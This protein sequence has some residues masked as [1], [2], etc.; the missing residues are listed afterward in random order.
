MLIFQE[1]RTNYS[2]DKSIKTATT[3]IMTNRGCKSNSLPNKEPST[4]SQDRRWQADLLTCDKKFAKFSID[5]REGADGSHRCSS[6]RDCATSESFCTHVIDVVSPFWWLSP[7]L[8]SKALY[9]P[10]QRLS[11]IV[12]NWLFIGP[13]IL[14]NCP[15]QVLHN[16]CQLDQH[17]LPQLLSELVRLSWLSPKWRKLTF[18]R[19]LFC[20]SVLKS[21]CPK[22]PFVLIYS[23]DLASG[24]II[25]SPSVPNKP[26]L[27]LTGS[28]LSSQIQ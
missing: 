20:P 17:F 19:H 28:W 12:P 10:P 3:W 8:F 6:H 5:N 2:A 18:Y 26:S 27:A 4:F 24:K 1:D 13:L 14:A 23:E 22:L 15:L 21:K 11:A 16:K 25:W 9:L 7:W